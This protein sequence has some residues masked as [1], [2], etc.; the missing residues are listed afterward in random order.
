MGAQSR[1]SQRRPGLGGQGAEAATLGAECE[2]GLGGGS[3][4]A[5]RWAQGQGIGAGARRARQAW[6]RAVTCWGPV[7]TQ[8][9][10]LLSHAYEIGG[11]TEVLAPVTLGHIGQA[12]AR[13]GLRTLTDPRLRGQETRLRRGGPAGHAGMT[14]E[15]LALART[16]ERVGIPGGASQEGCLEE[17]CR[18]LA[19]GTVLALDT[20]ACH[21]APLPTDPQR[22]PPRGAQAACP[23]V[24]AVSLP[25]LRA[26]GTAPPPVCTPILSLSPMV[27]L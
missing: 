13:V 3:G 1:Q 15:E 7:N 17:V 9:K 2:P 8:P 26:L 12:E 5:C 19:A 11:S 16:E 4:G 20:A 23:G 22:G 21:A 10:G 24:P 14:A 6:D 27:C 18:H 25:G